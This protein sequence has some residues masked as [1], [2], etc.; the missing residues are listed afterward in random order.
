M[1][2]NFKLYLNKYELKK[3]FNTRHM[4]EASALWNFFNHAIMK[5]M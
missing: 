5:K 4:K 1:I 3:N 2:L